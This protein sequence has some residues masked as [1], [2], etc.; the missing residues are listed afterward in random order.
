MIKFPSKNE[1]WSRRVLTSNELEDEVFITKVNDGGYL[2]CLLKDGTA[3]TIQIES[4][5]KLYR[6]KFT[7]FVTVDDL[8]N[9]KLH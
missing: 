7:S 6:Y 3:V 4:F 2:D 5:I 9:Y 1:V 8:F